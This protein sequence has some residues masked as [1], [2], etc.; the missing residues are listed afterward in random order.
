MSNYA[1]GKTI[2]LRH[3]YSETTVGSGAAISADLWTVPHDEVWHPLW[4]AVRSV[5]TTQTL[6]A[7][8]ANK[9]SS[10]SEAHLYFIRRTPGG[11]YSVAFPGKENDAE[12]AEASAWLDLDTKIHLSI[13]LTTAE[14][15]TGIVEGLIE[16]IHLG[17]LGAV[18]QPG[19]TTPISTVPPLVV[20]PRL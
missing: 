2:T 16:V 10:G 4:F 15:I 5:K 7:L 18:K 3:L 17:G 6:V 8:Y 13:T 11:A 12:L 14:T 1:Q 20:G 9:P 19:T